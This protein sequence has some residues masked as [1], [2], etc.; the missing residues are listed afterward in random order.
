MCEQKKSYTVSQEERTVIH[1]LVDK[2]MQAEGAEGV[3][4]LCC[5]FTQD[6][7][8]GM[9]CATCATG[10]M[11]MDDVIQGIAKCGGRIL[12]Q[13]EQQIEQQCAETPASEMRQ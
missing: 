1:G 5:S 6:G 4:V 3:M 8:Q 7:T 12:R 13:M 9:T 2:V 11:S 10:T